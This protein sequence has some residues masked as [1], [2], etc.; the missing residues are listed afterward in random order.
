M[1]HEALLEDRAAHLA[2]LAHDGHVVLLDQY[3]VWVQL[4]RLGSPLKQF[5]PESLYRVLDTQGLPDVLPSATLRQAE[6]ARRVQVQAAHDTK[7][8]SPRI[9]RGVCDDRDQWG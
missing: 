2:N 1:V 3:A 5:C 8:R 7:D 6:E 4:C 9:W